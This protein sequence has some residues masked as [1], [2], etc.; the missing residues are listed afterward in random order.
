MSGNPEQQQQ[1][2]S[3]PSGQRLQRIA[4]EGKFS[5]V[6][7]APTYQ[8][9]PP[10]NT[11][12]RDM[13]CLI[14]DAYSNGYHRKVGQVA[15]L[16]PLRSVLGEDITLRAMKLTFT[17]LAGGRFMLYVEVEVGGSQYSLRLPY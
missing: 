4:L 15:W 17:H 6:D 14:W 12:E 7:F 16:G 8:E 11:P 5:N 9:V 10:T 13:Q 3:N 2:I 1:Q